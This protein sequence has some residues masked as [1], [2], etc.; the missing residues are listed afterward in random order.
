MGHNFQRSTKIPDVIEKKK[1]VS[2]R[3]RETQT[4]KYGFDQIYKKNHEER[5]RRVLSS[6]SKDELVKHM[7]NLPSYLQRDNVKDDKKALNF[8]VLDWDRLEK[9]KKSENC[10]QLKCKRD[11]SLSRVSYT[12]TVSASIQSETRQCEKVIKD[13]DADTMNSLDLIKNSQRMLM[14]TQRN[15]DKKKSLSGGNKGSRDMNTRF[16]TAGNR[17]GSNNDQ[18]QDSGG[19]HKSIVLLLPKHS[20]NHSSELKVGNRKHY[21]NTFISEEVFPKKQNSKYR[22]SPLVSRSKLDGRRHNT[23]STCQKI[24]PDH[25]HSNVMKTPSKEES[26]HVYE[27]AHSCPL[28]DVSNGEEF[29]EESTPLSEPV[30][31][32]RSHA[33]PNR[34]FSLSLGKLS[35]SL[36]Y[37]ESKSNDLSVRSGPIASESR[38]SCH[39]RAKSSPLRR[40]LDPLLKHSDQSSKNVPPLEGTSNSSEMVLETVKALLHVSSRNGAPLF[41]LV[42]DN[43]SDIIV[44]M[45]RLPNSMK[46]DCSC[47]YSFYSVH[48]IKKKKSGIWLNQWNKERNFGFGFNTIGHMKISRLDEELSVRESVLYSV[49]PSL[50]DEETPELTPNREVAAVITKEELSENELLNKTTVVVSAGRHSLPNKGVLLPLVDRWKMCGKCDCGGWDVG[51]QLRILTSKNEDR[52]SKVYGESFNP[53]HLNLFLQGDN[54][55]EMKPIFSLSAMNKGVYSV[56][57]RNSISLLQAL[58]I[59]TAVIGGGGGKGLNDSFEAINVSKAKVAEDL[60]SSNELD[61]AKPRW[62]TPA[63]YVPSPPA[64]P[65][66]R[67]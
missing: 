47:V 10:N 42:V 34:L 52:S 37:K 53:D 15:M 33:S 59:S 66:G 19:G 23:S 8:G 11:V 38:T 67:V 7:S 62:M 65:V 43:S 4:S 14:V 45:K 48:E 58:F 61:G 1:H 50:S 36:S 39:T 26:N 29:K 41:K 16:T 5:G 12:S 57:F 18:K 30:S 44:A 3:C 64:S 28:P 49:D 17:E 40:L 22:Q 55:C 31:A 24:V 51:C 46:D 25:E 60:L 9:W 56:E 63:K 2:T 21:A 54:T 13:E 35:R 27:T 20:A 6:S 32:K